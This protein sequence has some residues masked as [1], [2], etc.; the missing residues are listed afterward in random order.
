MNVFQR[1]SRFLKYVRLYKKWA[2]TVFQIEVVVPD[3][4]HL[5]VY[6]DRLI[7]K[8]EFF[9]ANVKMAEDLQGM[10]VLTPV[11]DIDGYVYS[12]ISPMNMP[13]PNPAR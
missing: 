13:L 6:G 10:Y 11:P 7:V 5:V 3:A 8:S 1:V 4:T 12:P 9:G 2:R